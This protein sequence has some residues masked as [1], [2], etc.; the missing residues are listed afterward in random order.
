MLQVGETDAQP[1]TPKIQAGSLQN[2]Y[3]E[4]LWYKQNVASEVQLH[5]LAPR[6]W[7]LMRKHTSA[8]V[9]YRRCF[10]VQHP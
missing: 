2:H 6:S 7:L 5:T 10:Y 3:A 1:C 8:N 9:N 4:T